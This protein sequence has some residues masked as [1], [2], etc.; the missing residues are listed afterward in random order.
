M[1]V[2][3]RRV[4]LIWL[5][6]VGLSCAASAGQ[7]EPLREPQDGETPDRQRAHPNVLMI[8]VDDLNDCAGCLGG[9]AHTPNIDSLAARGTLFADA[10]CAAPVCN[11]SRVATLTGMRPSTTGIYDNSVTW[12]RVLPDLISLPQYL[13]KHGYYTAGGGKVYHHMPGFNRPADWNVRFD[14]VF[15]GPYQ[16]ML[17]TGVDVSH[18]RW[19]QG[20]PLNRISAVKNL[21]RPP[22]NAREF[23]WG[24]LDLE[25]SETGDGRMISW[26]EKLLADPPQQ[27]FFLAAGIF[28]PHLPFYAPRRFFELYDPEQLQLPVVRLDDCDDLPAAGQRMAAGRREDLEL[29]EREGR[30]R[31]F[32]HSYL[33]SVS[34]A[35]AMVGR[36][37][38][39]LASGP[40]AAD[41]LIVLWSDHGWHFGEKRALHKMTLWNRA[42]RVPL[43]IAI[44]QQTP[45]RYT[46]P[47][48]LID[49]FPTLNDLC[50]LPQIPTLDGGSLLSLLNGLRNMPEHPA[51]TTYGRGNHSVR[52][53]LG[54]LIRYADGSEEFY[55]KED[56]NEWVNLAGDSSTIAARAELSRWLP[57]EDAVPLKRGLR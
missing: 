54:T 5:F 10:H 6:C 51:L 29:V 27:P 22:R 18:F 35:D 9:Q 11:P 2:V 47:V 4:I 21:Q 57:K 56:V 30:F 41:T 14:Q 23:D 53:Q 25:A 48:G 46:H 16:R 17:S 15:D 7:P 8:I 20:Y 45:A 39:A 50:G 55:A 32:L 19:P 43:I 31:E 49:L 40:A 3:R 36:L 37:V 1:R 42:T 44:P 24:P 12:H 34:F 26:A 38:K 13:R 33:A 52:S 28:R